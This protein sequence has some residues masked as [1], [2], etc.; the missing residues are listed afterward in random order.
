MATP[1]SLG[2]QDG[3]GAPRSPI[4]GG[5]RTR[6]DTPVLNRLKVTELRALLEGYGESTAGLKSALVE[7]LRLQA[8]S[9]DAVDAR[10]ASPH[11]SPAR[12]W[13]AD[14]QHREKAE[15]APAAAELLR[16][17]EARRRQV[18]AAVE[19]EDNA[20]EWLEPEAE[21]EQLAVERQRLEARLAVV[22]RA[23]DSRRAGPAQPPRAMVASVED[24]MDTLQDRRA[25]TEAVRDAAGRSPLAQLLAAGTAGQAAA[26]GVRETDEGPGADT[27]ISAPTRATP[28]RRPAPAAGGGSPRGSPGHEA[29]LFRAWVDITERAATAPALPLELPALGVGGGSARESAGLGATRDSAG[30]ERAGRA[31]TYGTR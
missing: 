9:R 12:Q 28:G 7:R 6:P 1:P 4:R 23:L 22:T 2:A 26:A 15:E 25:V 11:D 16:T 19:T 18:G 31:A 21:L 5:A 29:G 20:V 3:G 24:L 13:R 30:S 27:T 17:L 10:P 8:T 14:G